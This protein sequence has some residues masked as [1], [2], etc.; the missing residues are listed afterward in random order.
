MTTGREHWV[1]ASSVCRR[2][3][4]GVGPLADE[5]RPRTGPPGP[6]RRPLWEVGPLADERRPRTGPPGP[7]RRPLWEVGLSGAMRPRRTGPLAPPT[8]RLGPWACLARC[9]RAKR[10]HPHHRPVASDRGPVSRDATAPNGPTRAAD[11]VA[12]DGGPV[13][14]DATAPNG[15]TRAPGAA[16]AF[17]PAQ[18]CSAMRL[19]ADRPRRHRTSPSLPPT[20]RRGLTSARAGRHRRPEG[21]SPEPC[22][23]HRRA[24][25]Q[26]C[27]LRP[28]RRARSAR[29][30]GAARR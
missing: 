5:A 17:N 4:R 9:H 30:S 14:R 15:P 2:R 1:P 13:W 28:R 26:S 3:T 27:A 8:R 12:S 16:R 18:V 24:R 22:G 6:S 21:G 20:T 29:R 23:R 11:P 10:A 19:A 7:S 25:R